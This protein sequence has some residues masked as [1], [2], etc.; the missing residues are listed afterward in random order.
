A[1]LAAGAADGEREVA[2]A[3]GQ[4]A[5]QQGL[6]Q[7]HEIGPKSLEIRIALDVSLDARIAAVERLEHRIVMRVLE[8]AHVEHQVGLARQSQLEGERYYRHGQS[9]AALAAE[10]AVEQRAELGRQ[11]ARGVDHPIGGLAQWRQHGALDCDA[12]ADRPVGGERMT[13]ARLL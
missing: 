4:E 3:L 8:E 1:V 10:A 9:R 7:T 5:R 11:Q 2:L 12:V 6:E 13:P